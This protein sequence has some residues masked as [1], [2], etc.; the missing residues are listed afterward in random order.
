MAY[1]FNW[2]YHGNVDLPARQ[3]IDLCHTISA[4]F[5]TIELD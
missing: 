4:M 5:E 1:S 3:R 2:N